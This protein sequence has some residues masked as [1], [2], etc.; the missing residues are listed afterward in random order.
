MK[1]FSRS[2]ACSRNRQALVVLSADSTDSPTSLYLSPRCACA[3]AKF[4]SISTARRNKGMAAALPADRFNFMPVLYAFRASSEDV[5]APASGVECFSTVA[6]DSP[7]RALSLRT[8][9]L[10]EFRT[11]S[12]LFAWIC[13]SSRMLP[14]LQF[15]ARRP[16][17][18][19][20][21]RVAIDPSTT[22][23]LAVLSQTCCA[24]R[25]VSLHTFAHT[26]ID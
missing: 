10:R 21:P 1:N 19:W 7:S 17:T 2:L 9:S 20:L 14:V 5:V 18:Y 12:L 4:G 25:Q 13:S 16:S 15:L 26:H 3:M 23:A 22:A 11:S 24:I 6:S 8:I